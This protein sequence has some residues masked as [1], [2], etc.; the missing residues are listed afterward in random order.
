[1]ADQSHIEELRRR[2]QKDPASIAFAQLAEELRRDGHFQEA[3]DI[4]RTGL[5]TY[6][7][8]SSA[9][10][11][12]ARALIGLGRLQ[13]ARLELDEALSLA[14]DNLAAQRTLA[15]IGGRE[16]LDTMVDRRL[17]T[18]DGSTSITVDP[19]PVE[20]IDS[21]LSGAAVSKNHEDDYLRALQV[22]SA[23]ESWLDAIR[24]HGRIRA[25]G[26]S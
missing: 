13:E 19:A 12:L 1:M 22:L 5:T 25:E 17:S 15:E 6:P 4:C 20:W 9:R 14:P 16:D 3:A 8:Y 11:T 26:C 7:K 10:V 18:V 2:L 24:T 21:R 23:L